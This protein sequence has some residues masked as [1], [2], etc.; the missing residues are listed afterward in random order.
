MPL[1]K[2]GVPSIRVSD[3]PNG[4]RGTKFFNG[5]TA[6]CFPCGT[7]L[8]A[9]WDTPLLHQA[10]VVMGEEAISKGAHVILGPTI[11]M[12]RSP[13]G[14]RGFESI[15]EDPVLAGLGAAALVKGI[16]ETGVVATIKHFV[17][18]DQEHERNAVNTIITERALREIY[19]LPFQLVVR[20]ANPGAFMT[21]YNKI[22]G[23]HVSE[24]PKILRDTL[25]GEWGWK[26]WVMSDWWGPYSTSGA[27]NAGLDL[28]MPGPTKYR[29]D[30]LL[31]AVGT[32]KVP[33]HILDERARNVLQLVNR[34]AASKIPEY[35]EEK[36]ANTPKTSALLRKIGAES[37]VLMKNEGNILPLKKDKK[38]Y[39][40]SRQRSRSDVCCIDID[41]WP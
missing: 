14:G 1:P 5:I 38:V 41:N 13:L 39:L 33:Q 3:G 24:N 20:D 28:E 40:P 12:Q 15:S 7:A 37:I 8:G 34:C 6:A 31:Q 27:A 16:Q 18:N 25:R 26:G 21:A 22:N 23:T 19:L 17:C 30:L 29:G 10:G 2:H 36:V 11:N 35:A 4:V 9:T 32:F